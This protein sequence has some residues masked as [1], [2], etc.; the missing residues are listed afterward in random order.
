MVFT[1]Y[2]DQTI[3]LLLAQPNWEKP[4]KVKLRFPWAE[5]TTARAG[6]EDRQ[7]YGESTRYTLE[8]TVDTSDA[9]QTSD[10][11]M[12]LDRLR[13]ELVAVPMWEDHVECANAFNA[14]T[15]SIPLA[16]GPPVNHGN[17]WLIMSPDG[18]TFEIVVRLSVTPTLLTLSTGCTLNWPAGTCAFPLLFGHIPEGDR[19]KFKRDTDEV[20]SGAIKVHEFSPFNRKLSPF[21]PGGSQIA[22]GGVPDFVTTPVFNIRPHH[23]EPIETTEVDFLL[24]ELGFWREAS[25]YS[26]PYAAARG[27][28]HTFMQTTREDI[29]RVNWFVIDRQGPTLRFFMPT[30]MGDLRLTQ[31]LP[32]S[33]NTS[34]ITIEASRYTDPDY[35]TNPGAPFLA[36]NDRD[37]ITCLHVTSI[38][39]A[40]LHTAAAISQSYNYKETKL[41]HLH[42][43]RLAQTEVEWTYDTDGLATCTLNTIEVP[44]EYNDPPAE[45]GPIAYLLK[46]ILKVDV[47]VVL[48]Y[49]TSYERK[50]FAWGQFWE[51]APFSRPLQGNA[52]PGRQTPVLHFRLRGARRRA[53]CEPAPDD[54]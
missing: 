5:V 30:F 50:I 4:I 18:S 16:Y 10:L 3:A 26:G 54:R 8:Y 45:K 20:I 21:D 39:G 2:N 40:G 51:P 53:C 1:S 14:G 15:T 6:D 28:K 47:D 33:G 42:L 43:S 17:L 34:L 31:D 19:P 22:G 27:L 7:P 37:H 35:S 25:V 48:G 38:D 32:I 13:D 11:K 24:R 49:F 41:S 36:L 44:N 12:W 52:R 29:A 9:R 23:S 46:F